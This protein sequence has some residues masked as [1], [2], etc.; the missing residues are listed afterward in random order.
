VAIIWNEGWAE[1]EGPGEKEIFDLLKASLPDSYTLINNISIPHSA[2]ADE[3]DILAIGP[4]AMFVV[5]V[6]SRWGR[7]EI[8]DQDFVKNGVSERNPYFATNRKAQR[9]K[10]LL[11]RRLGRDAAQ[12]IWVIPLVVI[13]RD[14]DEHS[15]WRVD[16]MATKV[17]FR[18]EIVAFMRPPSPLVKEA[19]WNR[20]EGM[21]TA[22]LD[23]ATGGAKP[24][25][26]TSQIGNYYLRDRVLQ[27]EDGYLARGTHIVNGA[28]AL[29]EVRVAGEPPIGLINLFP[30]VTPS[31]YVS[32]PREVFEDDG[33]TVLVWP[34]RAGTRF[35][36]FLDER[37][38]S[39]D[40][41]SDG[42]ILA[43]FIAALGHLTRNG[44]GVE[45]IPDYGLWVD[46]SG[47][48]YV[49][50][51]YPLPRPDVPEAATR[52]FLSGL[53]KRLAGEHPTGMMDEII[54]MLRSSPEDVPF[55]EIEAFAVLGKANHGMVVPAEEMLARFTNRRVLQ[56]HRFGETFEAMDEVTKQ[57]VVVKQESGRPDESWVVREYR[58]LSH[59]VERAPRNIPRPVG[60]GA[61]GD[62]SY[63]VVVS[64]DG[65]RLSELIDRGRFTGFDE[66]V[67][68]VDELLAT[69]E[70]IHPDMDGIFQLLESVNDEMNPDD[71]VR[72]GELRDSGVAHNLITPSNVII[73]D[74][75]RVVLIDFVR[76]ARFGDVIPLRALTVWPSDIPVDIS[77]P[78][79]DVFCAGDILRRLL[80]SVPNTNDSDAISM[81][82][83]SIVSK[84]TNSDPSK[85]YRSATEMRVALADFRVSGE[86]RTTKTH[87]PDEI[88]RRIDA[89]IAQGDLEGALELCP[90]NWHETRRRIEGKFELSRR[91]GV[92]LL[93]LG[94]FLLSYLGRRAV[95]P[96]TTA[97][98]TKFSSGTADTY[99][100]GVGDDCVLE[101]QCITAIDEVGERRRWVQVTRDLGEVGSLHHAVR[102]LRFSVME[103]KG[104]VFIELKQARLKSTP[105]FANQASCIKV[106]VD[107]LNAPLWGVD[108]ESLLRSFGATGFGTREEL[109][110][111]DSAKRTQL[112]VRV[113]DDALHLPAVVHL[114]TRLAPLRAGLTQ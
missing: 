37:G 59:F 27:F 29:L 56:R 92:L 50:L 25:D 104:C 99:R 110:G 89:R 94:D 43:G 82:L 2:G 85:R 49:V 112:A 88:A 20:I 73:T 71:A 87:G 65:E 55:S 98:N 105:N 103:A 12:A 40:H 101:V 48:G 34:P 26:R 93:N 83:N 16:E 45:N 41:E 113:G 80:E 102:S 62:F 46:P 97:S 109:F 107:E 18:N 32:A 61:E 81:G 7:L 1:F 72:L 90:S 100:C 19:H 106:N 91:E 33:R 8:L 74:D 9:L 17:V 36:V 63:L 60:G 69:L 28:A 76:A 30:R 6:K 58:L 31:T 3:I 66:V 4:D 64:E 114:I 23:A 44:L 79:A 67:D 24:R 77:D 54:G 84:A 57:K 68:I 5:E 13:H 47:N 38:D 70:K 39:P 96:G 53:V 75:D 15:I 42:P 78:R 86:I 11:E 108:A 111:D 21:T 35:D 22:I 95:G 51:D 10:S 52:D 14:F